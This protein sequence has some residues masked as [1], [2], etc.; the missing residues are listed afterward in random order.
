VQLE[1]L[2]LS[3]LNSKFLEEEERVPIPFCLKSPNSIST[4]DIQRP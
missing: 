1:E 4:R 3:S 2:L